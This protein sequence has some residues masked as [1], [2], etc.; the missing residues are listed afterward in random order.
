MKTYRIA[1]IAGDGIGKE[2]IPAAI[3]VLDIAAQRGGFALQLPTITAA[4][5][6]FY[7]LLGV[8][9]FMPV[10]GGLLLPRAS[11]T[12]ALV[13]IGAGIT[14]ALI[15]LVV[16]HPPHWWLDAGVV[17]LACAAL[18]FLLA[19]LFSRSRAVAPV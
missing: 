2:V 7:S 17:G 8:S 5:G 10:F 19:L 18:A 3:E 1:V 4:L 15:A 12:V 6:I 11:S 14:S 16:P 9:L 13:S